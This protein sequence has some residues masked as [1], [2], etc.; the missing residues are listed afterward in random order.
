MGSLRFTLQNELPRAVKISGAVSPATR[1]N[2]SMQPVMMPGD[3]VRTDME[4]T[5][6]QFG[7]PKPR[8]ASRIAFGTINSISSVVRQT[9]GIIMKPRATPPEAAE[10]CPVNGRNGILGTTISEYAARPI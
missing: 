6:R 7:K 8:A 9:V 1:A 5:D 4:R 2:A 10:K 3:A